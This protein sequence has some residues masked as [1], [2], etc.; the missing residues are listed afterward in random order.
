M[1]VIIAT[2]SELARALGKLTAQLDA[3]TVS[4]SGDGAVTGLMLDPATHVLGL[5][6]L[7]S[8]NQRSAAPPAVVVATPT[9]MDGLVL[10]WYRDVGTAE[11]SAR[12]LV[13]ASGNGVLLNGDAYLHDIPA[14]WIADAQRAHEMIEHGQRDR[15]RE[16]FA[17]H[18][19]ARV[20][21][22]ELSEVRR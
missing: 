7:I 3:S 2:P 13:S 19:H 14:A 15:A 21:S 20:F 22:G 17:T 12:E 8:A 5:V 6:Q 1:T 18:K 10:R 16:Q 11:R 9:M 4:P